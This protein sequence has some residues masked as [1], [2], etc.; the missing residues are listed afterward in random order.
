MTDVHEELLAAIAEG[1]SEKATR[2]IR[3][4]LDLNVPCEQGAP[5][6]Y[7]AILSGDV[8]LVRLML[9]HGADPNFAADEPAATIYADNPLE[10]AKQARFL[11]DKDKYHPVVTLLEEFGASER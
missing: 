3:S 6:L 4:G 11:M 9:E 1:D 10:L 8:L 2:L 7:P 5:V